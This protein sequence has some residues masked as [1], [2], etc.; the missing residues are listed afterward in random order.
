MTSRTKVLLMILVAAAA[1][2]V[3]LIAQAQTKP[4]IAYPAYPNDPRTWRHV[5]TRVVYS[6]ENKLFDQFG[7]IR[8]V[9]VNDIGWPSL[10][11]NKPYPD[12][13]MFALEVLDTRTY[14]GAIEPRGRKLLAV[15]K[16][17]SKLYAATG[18]WGFEVFQ[19]NQTTGSLKDAKQCFSCHEKQKN[20]D[21]IYSEYMQ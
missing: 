1:S 2:L 18:G 17:N 10:Q 15:M 12:G 3:T 20:R 21:Y 14:Q 6:K 11:R 13:S 4:A 7:G 8:N 5:S 9:Y 16:K 19:P